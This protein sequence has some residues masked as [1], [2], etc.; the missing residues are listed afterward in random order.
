MLLTYFILML[1]NVVT[2][3]GIISFLTGIAT[4]LLMMGRC[5]YGCNKI[6]PY[7]KAS[8]I[9]FIISVIVATFTPTTKQA[10]LIFLSGQEDVVA[11]AKNLPKLTKLGTDYLI[12]LLEEGKKY[13][14]IGTTD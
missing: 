7:L 13:D 1:D 10:A 2:L 3:S 4:L 8:I 9:T 5:I 12:E 14:D 6:V 11:T